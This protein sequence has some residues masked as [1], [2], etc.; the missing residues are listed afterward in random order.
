MFRNY[1][2]A[3]FN[4]LARNWL[5][6]GV[7]ILGLAV[8]FAAAIL[9][10]LYVRDEYS[11]ER[12]IPGH[13]DAYLVGMEVTFP[14]QKPWSID[15]TQASIAAELK[16]DFPEVSQAARLASSRG[17]LKRG[18]VET[19]EAIAWATPDFFRILPLPVLAGDANAALAAPDGLVLTRSMARKIFGQDVPIGR[20]LLLNPGLDAVG[21]VSPE[22]KQML[23]AYHPMRVMAVLQDIPSNTHLKA[24]IFAAGR[25]PFSPTSMDDRHPAPSSETELT[26]VKLRPGASV[27]SISDRLPA[28]ADRRYPGLIG[29]GRS[30]NRYKLMPLQSLHFSASGISIGVIRPPGDR[31]VDTGV[32]V[33]GALTVIIAAINFVTLM[34]ARATRRA[35]EVGVR[36]AVGA[37]RRD[38]IVQFMGEALLYVLAGMLV[39]VALAELL[40]PYVNAFLQRSIRFDYLAD[41]RLLAAILGVAVL[42][43]LLAGVYPAL[44]ISG[45]RPAAALKGGA[46]A[47]TGSASVRQV[48]VVVQFAVLIGLLVM[49][50]TIYRQTQ[51]ALHDSLRLDTSQAAWMATPCRSAFRQQ[52][53]ALPGVKQTSCASFAALSLGT[54][55]TAVIMADR[56]I[57]LVNVG[58]VDLGFLKLHGLTPLAGRFPS[59]AY[60][61]DV[62][63]DRPEPNF[64]VQPTVVLNESAARA[65]GFGRPADAVG[66]SIP[67]QRPS[68]AAPGASMPP[69]QSSRVVGVV[70]D[71]TLGSIRTPIEPTLYYIDP[72]RARFLV[73]KL[74]GERLPETLHG[75]DRAWRATG[76][77]R[78]AGYVFEDQAVQNL[79]RDVVAQGVV[80][81]VCAALAIFIACLGLFALAAFTTE[82]RTKEIGVRKAMGASTTDVMKL[83]LWQFSQPVLWANLIAWPL[84][85]WAMTWWLHGFAYHVD[86][87]VWL[88]LAASSGAVVIA[89]ATVSIHAWLV[90]RAKPVTALRYE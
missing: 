83:L 59:R 48:L 24:E 67:W 86:L 47:P 38:L 3:A 23:T 34:T 15:V 9:I 45:F 65:I 66:K 61:E 56:S 62:V 6:A 10:G 30:Y 52:I 4:G 28:F 63:L 84:A 43:A 5:Y 55:K 37:R 78:P 50:G 33:V 53:D 90:A 1:L 25:A 32:A 40:L 2:S 74:D 79:Y 60:G 89:W 39:A 41:P 26:Y 31:S 70:R 75:I 19:G 13:Q 82:R 18:D 80:I 21:G 35:V 22:E 49:T 8:G 73:M 27:Q 14:G 17:F 29:G 12:F 7:T 54:T 85:W 16:L 71:F 58:E 76:H 36:K 69:V 42:T 87:P 11:F 57:R 44:I 72:Y 64:S 77:D 20:T 46:G 81:G 68:A 51:F 88:F